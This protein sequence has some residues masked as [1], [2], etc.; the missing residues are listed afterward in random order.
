MGFMKLWKHRGDILELIEALV[1]AK[2]AAD[3]DEDDDIDVDDMKKWIED[4]DFCKAIIKI[5]RAGLRLI[6]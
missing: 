6:K 1:V 5:V 4:D 2:S 3:I